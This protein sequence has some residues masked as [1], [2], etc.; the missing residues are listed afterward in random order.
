MAPQVGAALGEY[1]SGIV[2]RPAVEG[3]EDRGFDRQMIT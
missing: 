2:V 3:Q 1:Q